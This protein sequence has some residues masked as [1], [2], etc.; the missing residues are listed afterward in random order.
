M[1]GNG[2]KWKLLCAGL[3]AAG[4]LAGMP[5]A[6]VPVA[7]AMYST[8]DA[9]HHWYKTPNEQQ[10]LFLLAIKD[11]DYATAKDMIDSGV[12]V[13]GVYKDFYSD[14]T[15]ALQMAIRENNRNI[16]QLLLEQGAQ[17]T[18]FTDFDGENVDYLVYA[19]QQHRED[20]ELVKYLHAWGADIN[21][22]TTNVGNAL[23]FIVW[24]GYG[25]IVYMRLRDIFLSRESIRKSK[26]VMETRRSSTLSNGSSIL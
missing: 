19:L 26:I 6:Q 1:K 15:T 25:E 5:G 2:R 9:A 14:G 22:K 24:N 13:N 23:T 3:A 4:V 21:G 17:V 11:N 10:K 8:V 16:M 18:G 7:E 20:L 12:D